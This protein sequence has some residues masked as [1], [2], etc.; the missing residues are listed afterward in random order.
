M[1]PSDHVE[2]VGYL[3]LRK[4]PVNE[5]ADTVLVA[6]LE[7]EKLP[8]AGGSAAADKNDLLRR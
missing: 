8:D 1:A 6:K 7:F 3:R 5:M 4:L 2:H